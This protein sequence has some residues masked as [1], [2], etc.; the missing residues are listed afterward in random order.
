MVNCSLVRD[1]PACSRTVSLLRYRAGFKGTPRGPGRQAP[2]NRELHQMPG[3]YI[4]VKELTKFPNFT[5]HNG[6]NAQIL[7]HVCRNNI[8]SEFFFWGGGG[9]TPC[10]RPPPAKSGPAGTC[11]SNTLPV[12]DL[13]RHPSP[14]CHRLQS[15]TTTGTVQMKQLRVV[16][17]KP[18]TTSGLG[19][20]C[21]PSVCLSVCLSVCDV[22]GL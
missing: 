12:I 6:Q 10:P 18:P 19:I 9:G 8:F 16:D 2:T 20:A 13:I 1:T 4:F 5:R 3:F 15:A 7:C 17:S 11:L 21:R 14:L 22:G